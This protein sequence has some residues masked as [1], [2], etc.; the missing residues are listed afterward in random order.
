MRFRPGDALTECAEMDH[1]GGS[2]E[3]KTQAG[4]TSCV[5]RRPG[6]NLPDGYLHRS[7]GTRRG[8]AGPNAN[9][10]TAPRGE[11]YYDEL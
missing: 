6:R 1:D 9:N 10:R 8:T 2:K 7:P 3:R 5:M 4:R 11:A